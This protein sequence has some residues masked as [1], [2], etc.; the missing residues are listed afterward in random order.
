MPYR[1]PA[2]RRTRRIRVRRMRVAVLLVVVA[3]TAA[4]GYES[5]AS[6]SST[7]VLPIDVSPTAGVAVSNTVWP[8]DGQAAFVQTGQSQIHPGPNQHPAAIASIAKVMTAYL[9]L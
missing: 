1:D 3:A 5:L 6:T 8:A 9:V 4:L 2:R 7:A